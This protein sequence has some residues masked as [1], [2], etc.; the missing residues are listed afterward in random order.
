MKTNSTIIQDSQSASGYNDQ[1]RKTNWFGPE[2]VFF[3]LPTEIW[4]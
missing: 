2:V 1:A 4:Q 3:P